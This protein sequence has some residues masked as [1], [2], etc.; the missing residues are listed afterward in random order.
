M[1]LPDPTSPE[2]EEVRLLAKA[3]AAEAVGNFVLAGILRVEAANTQSRW[4]S[5]KFKRPPR[6]EIPY[7]PPLY[8]CIDAENH[9]PEPCANCRPIRSSKKTARMRTLTA[10][11]HAT[12]EAVRAHPSSH[13]NAVL[14]SYIRQTL[15]EVIGRHLDP[16]RVAVAAG[17]LEERGLLA[18][19]RNEQDADLLEWRITEQGLDYLD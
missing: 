14:V 11:Q 4:A 19:Q 17:Q 3:E 10:I 12:L 7:L 6:V 5:P 16:M 8:S 2:E 1:D 13:I 9:S 15:G 18:Y